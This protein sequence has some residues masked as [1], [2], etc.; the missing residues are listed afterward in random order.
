MFDY[1][2]NAV[3][4]HQTESE[5]KTKEAAEVPGRNIKKL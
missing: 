5:I 2:K 3:C 4:H 1:V